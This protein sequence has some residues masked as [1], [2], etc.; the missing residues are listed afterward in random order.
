M[1]LRM[2][3]DRPSM[4]ERF[5][6]GILSGIAML[7]AFVMWGPWGLAFSAATVGLYLYRDL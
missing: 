7:A 3:Q 4:L 6:P 5:A 1:D 2:T